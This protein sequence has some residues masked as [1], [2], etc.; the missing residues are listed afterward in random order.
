MKPED[1]GVT[2]FTLLRM[3]LRSF[4]LQACWN[5]QRVQNLG[6]AYALAPAIRAVES[7]R[8]LRA[9]ALKR[10]L[11]FFVTHP[12]CASLILGVVARLEE[13]SIRERDTQ[14][15]EANRI[16]LGMMG[17]LAALG[18]SF[19]WATLKPATALLGV[20]VVLFTPAGKVWPA[21][22]GPGVFL[23]L[24]SLAHLSLRLGGV[25]LGYHRGLE[26]IQDL[27]RLNPQR[28][29]RY[30]GLFSALIAG[31]AAA[32]YFQL[33]HPLL[34][35]SHFTDAGLLMVLMVLLM[36]GLRHG[37]SASH[38]FYLLAALGLVSGWLGLG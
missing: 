28:W 11:E 13:K 26:I 27:R 17:P 7:V 12:Y 1:P 23:G 21:L 4:C 31:V 8:E 22:A 5:F 33:R 6:F 20:C 36:G 24:F 32:G 19:F 10:H 38:L 29:V 34:S 2:S 37:L 30:I 15:L 3:G 16:K 25:F 9:Q 14:A 35:N 18:D